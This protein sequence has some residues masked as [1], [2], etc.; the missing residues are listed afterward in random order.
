MSH[1]N[2]NGK[3][4]AILEEALDLLI[5]ALKKQKFATSGTGERRI[6]SEV[7]EKAWERDGGRCAYVGE[8][9]RRCGSAWMV[10]FD[11]IDPVAWGGGAT[12]DK[13]RCLCWAHNQLEA[14]RLFGADF[15]EEKR[16]AAAETR[17]SS[18]IEMKSGTRAGAAGTATGSDE[19]TRAGAGATAMGSD[20]RTRA[21]AGP[22]DAIPRRVPSATSAAA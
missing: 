17:R 21:G 8:K 11:H 22:S 14:E 20:D 1:Q 13:I 3:F 10:E 19:G 12:L 15:M 7:K 2:P 4:E 18:R 9:G 6:T 5:P 16:R